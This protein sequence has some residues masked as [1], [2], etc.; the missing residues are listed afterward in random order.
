MM[1]GEDIL[2]ISMLKT[3]CNTADGLMVWRPARTAHNII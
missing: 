1:A 3:V 2:N